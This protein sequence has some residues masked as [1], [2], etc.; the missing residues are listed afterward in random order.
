MTEKRTSKRLALIIA[1]YEYQDDSLRQLVAPAQDAEALARVLQN[2]DI[3]SFQVQILLNEPAHR[4]SHTIETFFTGRKRDD[5]LLL[6]FSGHGIKD[7]WGR[8][9]FATTDTRRNTPRTTAVPASLVN[10]VMT[11][12]R[13]RRQVLLLDCCYSGAFARTKADQTVGVQEQVGGRGRVVLTSSNAVQ[14]SFEGDEVT[15]E[16]V[17]SVFTSALVRGLKT[18]EADRDKD[19]RISLDELYDYVYERVVDETPKQRPQMFATVEGKIVIALNPHLVL[20]PTVLPPELQQAIESPLSGVRE[21]TVSELKRMLWSRNKNLVL[22]VH[23]ALTRLTNDDNFQVSTVAALAQ[24]HTVQWLDSDRI[25]YERDG[26]EMIR[27]P[28]GKFLYGNK[29]EELELPEFWIDKTPVTNAEYARFI[30]ATGRKRS[31]FLAIGT[32][33]ENVANHPVTRVAWHDAVVYAEWAG[34]R[35]PTEKEWEKAARGTD[36]REYPWGDWEEGRCNSEETNIG[37][38]TPA[39]QYSPQGNS[40]YGCADMAGNVWEWTSSEGKREP[41]YL[42]RVLRGGSWRRGRGRTCHAVDNVVGAYSAD[43]RGFR[44]VSSTFLF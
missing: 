20:K 35:L 5:L 2:P 15:G 23:E 19:G 40:P 32:S 24:R 30:E 12:S 27:I 16:G 10:D 17:S 18:G 38:T 9:Y 42:T 43:D 1:S 25:I 6:Y 37:T 33:L 11:D 31:G 34:K 22:A 14:Y 3:G 28:A 44:C 29:K 13:S 26:K 8:L 41:G 7:D 39:G 4:V 21:G 36:G